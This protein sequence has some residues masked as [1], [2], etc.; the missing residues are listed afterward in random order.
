MVANSTVVFQIVPTGSS[1]GSIQGSGVIDVDTVPSLNGYTF[2]LENPFGV[3][4]T[5]YSNSRVLNSSTMQVGEL[6]IDLGFDAGPSF[7]L[8]NSN[9]N[10]P[11]L[12]FGNWDATDFA[13][14][15]VVSGL[16][17]LTLRRGTS[18][19]DS[20]TSGNL[21]W[22]ADP[23]GNQ[24]L[25]GRWEVVGTW[26]NPTEVPEPGTL[27]LLG[28]GLAGLAGARRCWRMRTLDSE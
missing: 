19:A 25:V 14:G 2:F 1:S 10:A 7:E 9:P 16:L 22:G 20:G 8:I 4:P 3:G 18:W 27:A 21:W 28:L 17:D 26:E 15:S 13:P 5:G 23:D 6:P 11:V 24:V 12:Y